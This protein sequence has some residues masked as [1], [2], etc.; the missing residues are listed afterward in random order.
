MPPATIADPPRIRAFKNELVS[1]IP[2]FPNDRASL[3]AL[4][5]KPISRLVIDY[6]N[7]RIRYVSRRPRAVEI[8]PTAQHDPRWAANGVAISLLLDKVRRGEDLTPHLST[9]PHSRGFIPAAGAAGASVED[10]WSDKDQVLNVMG[11]H[12]FHLGT[13]VEPAGHMTRTNDLLF[14]HVSGDLFTAIALFGHEV[15]ESGSSERTRLLT[16][17]EDR[18]AQGVPAGDFVVRAAVASS[19]H[20][21]HVVRYAQ[22]CVREMRTIEPKLDDHTELVEFYK[23]TG[24]EI[25]KQ[26]KFVWSFNNLDFGFVDKT[27]KIFFLLLKGW[28]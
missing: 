9:E 27:S 17:H 7:W 8:E 22:A 13:T 5:Q 15:F 10:K 24:R 11:F 14:A 4:Q 21:I 1:Q 12:H 3:V 2:R 19:G 16:V 20:P 28:A 6:L 26:P 18:I 23:A 25:P